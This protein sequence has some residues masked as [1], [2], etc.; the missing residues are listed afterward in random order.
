MLLSPVDLVTQDRKRGVGFFTR[1]KR[2][3]DVDESA[4]RKL[5]APEECHGPLSSAPYYDAR[6]VSRTILHIDMDAFYASVEELDEPSLRG[7]PLIVGGSNRRGVVL[8]ASYA[9]RK[10]GVHSAMSMAEAM[11]LAPHAV[12]VPPRHARYAAISEHV[13]EI[14]HRFSPIVEGLSIDEA[15]MDVTGSRALFGDGETIARAIKRAI[16]EEVGLTASAGVAPSKFVAKI[17]SD[18]RKPD[19]LVVVPPE[20]VAAFLAPLPIERMWGVGPK[21]APK[22]RAAGF[23]TF[24]DLARAS[25]T[26]LERNFGSHGQD[27]RALARGEDVREVVPDRAAKSIGA[28]ET[29]DDDL[30]TWEDVDRTMLVHATRV[31]ARLVRAELATRVVT[32]KI[33][34]ADFSL[35]TKRVTLDEPAS[36][37]VTIYEAA[38]ASIR[39]LP[40]RPIRLTGVSTSDFVPR[41]AKTTL[42]PDE[43]LERRKRVE[44][45]VAKVR[46]KFEADTRGEA[47]RGRFERAI[48]TAKGGLLVPATLLESRRRTRER[49]D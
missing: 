21:T 20:D 40:L 47:P 24:A 45:L 22:M 26:S 42:F 37:S 6:A 3:I 16:K 44:D 4:R 25:E 7:K 48:E 8:A 33:K 49:E 46:D 41:D 1:E 30:R 43:K 15:F 11:R 14:F 32:A 13:F 19:G 31:A 10:F 28:E 39:S 2:A 5:H 34:Y 17:A 9:V 27:M 38:R 18:F 23:A 35:R 12:V 36:D 29:Y